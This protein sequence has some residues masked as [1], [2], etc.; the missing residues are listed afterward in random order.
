[1]QRGFKK[2]VNRT[3]LQSSEM[4]LARTITN[5]PFSKALLFATVLTALALS[6][7]V[8]DDGHDYRGD[9]AMYISQ[10]QAMLDGSVSQ[11]YEAN[12]YAMDNSETNLGPYLYQFGF[13]SLLALV[14]K[15][16]GVNFFAFKGLCAV[17]FACSIPIIYSLIRPYFSSK[18]EPWLIT[19]LIATN[20][21]YVIFTNSVLSDLPFL[22]FCVISLWALGK[23]Q[24][25]FKAFFLGLLF[26]FSYLIRDIGIVLIPTYFVWQLFNSKRP[27]SL[28]EGLNLSL[29][30]LVF[31]IC[32]LIGLTILPKGQENHLKLMLSDVSWASLL[33]NLNYYRV[34]LC[35]FFYL[36]D[37]SLVVLVP[38]FL[39][40]MGSISVY[41]KSPYLIAFTVLTLTILFIWPFKQ[42]LRFLFPLLP[43]L[44]LSMFKGFELLLCFNGKTARLKTLVLVGFTGMMLYLSFKEINQYAQKETNLCYSTEQIELYEFVKKELPKE[45]IMAHYYPRV[46]RLFTGMNAV[47]QSQY[48]F[49]L[50][51]DIDY[52]HGNP[53]YTDKN[54]I[55]KYHVLY[56]S[57]NELILGKEPLPN[58]S[59]RLEEETETDLP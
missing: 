20:S 4:K 56:E 27:R 35:R 6:Y 43:F 3:L 51:S 2:R 44:L 34:L 19:W 31:S 25:W 39:M 14:I 52:F 5:G 33:D 57:E 53:F 37:A 7:W 11:L 26:Y 28:F 38:I 8:I 23:K 9:F 50:R 42:G 21:A 15:V 58:R 16:Y 45:A 40:V 30:Y 55:A 10:A 54:V 49:D 22:F 48:E 46:F 36:N 41:K 47:R 24:T 17:A 18:L 32:F 29:P 1:M 12:R 13:P 59:T